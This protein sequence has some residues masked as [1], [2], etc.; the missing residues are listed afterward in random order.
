MPEK[1]I[2]SEKD[3]EKAL[4]QQ[5][6]KQ[7]GWSIKLLPFLNAGLPDRLV[8]LPKGRLFFAEV[9]TTGKETKPIQKVIISKIEKLGFRVEVIDSKAQALAI[10]EE[11]A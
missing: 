4:G 3:I 11:Y 1:N 7:G 5:A 6:K 9:K 2:E 10:L 8:L